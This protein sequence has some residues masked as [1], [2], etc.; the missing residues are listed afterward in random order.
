MIPKFKQ[1]FKRV[2]ASSLF[3]SSGV[4][5]ISSFINAGI[6]LIL[7]PILTRRLTPV[8]YGVVAMFQLTIN[9]I[10]PFIGMNLEGAIA[11]KYYDKDETDFPSYIGSCLILVALSFLVISALFGVSFNYIQEVTQIPGPWLIY[12]L[13]V[14]I[15]QFLTTVVLVT[16]Q[17]SVQ[18][19]KY[20]VLQIFQSIL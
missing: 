1:T 13:L 14:A 16:Y 9:A 20:G 17:V 11:R 15:C 12:V 4:Y 18:P 3:R 6:P 5:T 19:I 10:F 2:L 7:L 8:D